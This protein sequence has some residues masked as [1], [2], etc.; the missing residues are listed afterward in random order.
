MVTLL[1]DM[2][3]LGFFL[4]ESVEEYKLTVLSETVILEP[5]LV[6]LSEKGITRKSSHQTFHILTNGLSHL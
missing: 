2:S 1:G 6:F 4:K 5:I 3:N